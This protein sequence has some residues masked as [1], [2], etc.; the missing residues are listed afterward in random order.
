MVRQTLEQKRECGEPTL[1]FMTTNSKLNKETSSYVLDMDHVWVH[2][3]YKKELVELGATI[4]RSALGGT[5][6]NTHTTDWHFLITREDYER[7]TK[8]WKKQNRKNFSEKLASGHFDKNPT[9]EDLKNDLTGGFRLVSV[10]SLVKQI[11]EMDETEE[12]ESLK[13][14]LLAVKYYNLEPKTVLEMMEMK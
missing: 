7:I 8:E 3:I 10:A 9:L 5:I 14:Q 11:E 6:G 4:I 1:F 2:D 13:K 12:T